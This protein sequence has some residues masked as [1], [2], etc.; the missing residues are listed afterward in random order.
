MLRRN[1]RRTM[2]GKET[3]LTLRPL[4]HQLSP[5]LVDSA[6]EDHVLGRAHP[7]PVDSP[8]SWFRRLGDRCRG[9]CSSMQARLMKVWRAPQA[10]RPH[11]TIQSGLRLQGQRA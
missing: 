10:S 4:V 1:Q 5:A 8:E 11:Q 9:A 7:A 3:A 6:V 2:P